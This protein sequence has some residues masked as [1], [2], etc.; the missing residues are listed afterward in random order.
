LETLI[1]FLYRLNVCRN[2]GKSRIIHFMNFLILM[3]WPLNFLIFL[4]HLDFAP[5][6]LDLKTFFN[7][8]R[9]EN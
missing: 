3:V 4:I 6:H 1:S 9:I 8:Q 2:R 5:I 7:G